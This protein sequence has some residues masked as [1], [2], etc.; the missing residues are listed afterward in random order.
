MRTQKEGLW[1]GCGAC[2]L[3]WMF[4]SPGKPGGCLPHPRLQPPAPASASL[5]PVAHLSGDQHTMTAPL[6]L[7]RSK[8]SLGKILHC[9]VSGCSQ[10]TAGCA[11][12]RDSLGGITLTSRARL[13]TL[14]GHPRTG[15]APVQRSIHSCLG[16]PSPR[17]HVMGLVPQVQVTGALG[18]G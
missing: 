8:S 12:Q 13:L 10:A 14:E 7:P 3:G 11:L 18:E 6:G 15:G 5:C 4:L 1:A 17:C 16:C 9:M 2:G